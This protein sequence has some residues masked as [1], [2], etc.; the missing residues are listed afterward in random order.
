[1]SDAQSGAD[2]GTAGYLH[3]RGHL[4]ES[5]VPPARSLATA[6]RATQ[7]IQILER[8]EVPSQRSAISAALWSFEALCARWFLTPHPEQLPKRLNLGCGRCLA[9]GWTNADFAT[10]RWSLVQR[11][12]PSDWNMDATRRWRCDDNYFEAIH[13]EHVLEHFPYAVA[14]G[15]LREC[16]R[17]LKHEGI[18]RVILPDLRR[19]LRYYDGTLTGP[20]FQKFGLGPVA[21][22]KLTQCDR[23]LSVW[24]GPMLCSVLQELG[25]SDVTEVSFMVTRMKEPCIDNPIREWESV[26]VEAVKRHK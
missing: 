19:F 20:Q 7:V 13:C 26:Y 12:P 16:L 18:L 21:I 11:H 23:H 8:A 5:N 9:K 14:V 17:T 22:S 1:M 10:L 6:P 2:R 15:V 24:D 3:S 4:D 25:F